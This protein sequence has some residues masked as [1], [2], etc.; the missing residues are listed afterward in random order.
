[1]QITKTRTV[2]LES[3]DLSSWR[4]DNGYE[5]TYAYYGDAQNIKKLP[6]D[7]LDWSDN[8]MADHRSAN[9][10][11]YVY[12]Q[13]VESDVSAALNKIAGDESACL[14]IRKI[15]MSALGKLML[16]FILAERFIERYGIKE[17]IDFIPSAFP[18]SLYEIIAKKEGLV[19][20]KIQ[21]PSWYLKKMKRRE[22]Y[23]NILYRIAL[24]FYPP[25]LSLLMSIKKDN[26]SA[27]KHY[28]YGIYMWNSGL[29]FTTPPYKM[30][31]LESEN[32]VNSSNTLYVMDRKMDRA[33]FKKVKNNG[34]DSCHF[35][36]MVQDFSV[37]RYLKKI[38]PSIRQIAKSAFL[39][40]S[41]K[42]LLTE[43]YLRTL[44]WYT[45]WKMFYSEYCVETFIA[46]QEPGY[47]ERVLYQKSQGSKNLFVYRSCQYDAVCRKDMNTHIETYY[48]FMIYDAM[49]SSRMSNN[50]FRKN[51]NLIDEYIDCGIL[52]SD[53]VYRTKYNKELKEKIRRELGISPGKTVIGFFDAGIG[54]TGFV[55]NKEGCK[56]MNDTYR[57]IESNDNYCLVF[58][59]RNSSV[60]PEMND[61]KKALDKL[62][63]HSRVF[64]VNK[65]NPHYKAYDLLGIC[66]LAIGSFSSSVPQESIAGGIRTIC[67]APSERHNKEVF[68]LN[69]LPRFWAH[70]YEELEKYTEYWLNE[71]SEKKFRDFQDNY[72]KKHVDNHCDGR[73]TERLHSILELYPNRYLKEQKTFKS[74]EAI[75]AEK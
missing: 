23:K 20:D 25:M 29:D 28:K 16:S 51:N 13:Y 46:V 36:K 71:C 69:R 58:N 2:L 64:Y 43:S 10:I 38:Y 70:S 61:V 3:A 47:I 27:I 26:T 44:R 22:F 57:I 8:C 41:S 45:L 34:Y 33:N 30:E 4:T 1:M 18:Y 31:F 35:D 66:D 59:S 21:I 39:V 54:R 9:I 14:I 60:L 67:Y 32:G 56:A 24:R 74:E 63:S 11:D 42:V 37:W 55:N 50:Y 40:K 73:A 49:I 7:F 6:Y 62:A 19:F 17:T 75:L 65:L 53:I 48:G 72:I 68:V 52:N 12:G 5:N 15:I